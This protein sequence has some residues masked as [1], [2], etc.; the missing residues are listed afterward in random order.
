MN[1]E[2]LGECPNCSGKFEAV[3]VG[4]YT[5]DRCTSCAGL[6]LDERELEKVLSMDHS[7]LRQKRTETDAGQSESRKKGKC[8]RC[9]GTLIQLTNLRANV[10][11]DSC[12]VCYG[13][14]LDAGELDRFD[15]PNLAGRIGGL[16]RRLIGKH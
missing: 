16:L 13:V 8:P 14:F 6:W 9:G 11:T 10:K 4:T 5:I 15:H 3:K 1:T 7:A 2:T 12:T